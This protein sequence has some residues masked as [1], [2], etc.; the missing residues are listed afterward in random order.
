MFKVLVKLI[1]KYKSLIAYAFF[2]GCTTIINVAAYFVCSKILLINI[3]PA[4]VIAWIAAVLFAYVT[5][6]KWVFQSEEKTF[7]GIMREV[8]YFFS[9]RL[10]TGVLDIVVMHVFAEILMMN[11]VVIKVVSNILVIIINYVVSKLI[12]FKG[13][14]KK[15]P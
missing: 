2:G 9:C 6:R 3:I 1:K 15:Q 4:T 14:E 8:L 13:K 12:I 10:M 7:K 11:D 5:N